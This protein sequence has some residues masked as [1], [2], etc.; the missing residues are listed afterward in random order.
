MSVSFR[1]LSPGFGLAAEGVNL[2]EPLDAADAR[3]I[4][5][6]WL[7]ANGVLVFRNQQLSPEQHVAFSANFGEVYVGGATNNHESPR[8]S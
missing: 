6:A 7:D 3:A 2:S 1:P 4:R 8:V 5:Q